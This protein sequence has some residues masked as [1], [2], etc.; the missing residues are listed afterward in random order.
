MS[1]STCVTD[2]RTHATHLSEVGPEISAVTIGRCVSNNRNAIADAVM[3]EIE[4]PF[5]RSY[6]KPS[7]IHSSH[8]SAMVNGL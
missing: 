8:R 5:T 7:M 4:L 2:D 3:P 1:I 6:T